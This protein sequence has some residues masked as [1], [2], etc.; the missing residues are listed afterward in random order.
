MGTTNSNSI[1][2]KN[3]VLQQHLSKMGVKD[4]SCYRFL[5]KK[6]DYSIILQHIHNHMYYLL[7]T[8]T[9]TAE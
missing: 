9:V 7:R 1:D 8:L 6:D 4:V 2:E 5:E 3:K